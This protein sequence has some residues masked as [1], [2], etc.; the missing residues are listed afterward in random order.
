MRHS[1]FVLGICLTFGFGL[2]ALAAPS[3]VQVPVTT[4][5]PSQAAHL[6]PLRTLLDAPNGHVD[7]ARSKLA[8][9]GMI[10]PTTDVPAALA[11]IERLSTVIAARIPPGADDRQKLETMLVTL[12]QPGSWNDHRPFSYDLDDPLGST[13]RNKLLATYL[14]TRKGNCVSMPM[15]LVAIGQRLGLP[16]TL[17]TAPQHVLVKFGD[18]RSG[19]WLNV[20]ATAGGFESDSGYERRMHIAPAAIENELYLRPL[21][22]REAVGVMASTYM[23][24]LAASKRGDDLLAVSDMLLAV[25][26]RDVVAMMQKGN[27]YYLQLEA[28]YRQN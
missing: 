9:D 1:R 12:Y 24:V 25:N 20:E 14:A 10:D 18:E 26:P 5:E 21:A 7:F 8:I 19:Q 16:I 17:A 4:T 15:L 6:T 27:A 22:P 13:R 23:E 3:G 11:E 28:R 2:A